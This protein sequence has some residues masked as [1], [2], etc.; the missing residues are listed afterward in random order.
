M[1][2]LQTVIGFGEAVPWPDAIT[3]AAISWL[4]TRT[5]QRLSKAKPD[6][7]RRFAASMAAYPI[8]LHSAAA[9]AQHYEIPQ[10]FF[11][12][13]LGPQRKYSC[14]LY[15][16]GTDTLAAA[17]ERALQVTAHHAGLADGQCIL[18][19]GCGWGSLSLWLAQ[20]YR[21]ARITAVSNSRSQRE[22]ILSVAKAQALA[23][24]EV[25][26]ADMNEF[27]PSGRFDRIVSVEMF[28][29]MANWRP[30]LQRMRDCVEA[31][32]RMFLHIFANSRAPYRFSIDERA[33][34][35]AQHY[36][37]GG[38]MPSH[39]L[40]RQFSDCFAVD[41]EWRWDG[42]HYARTARHW[43]QNFDSNSDAIS[44][45]LK[46]I[47]GADARLWRRRWR[48]FFLATAGLFAHAGGGEWG[49]S[50][51]LLAPNRSGR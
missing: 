12:L 33:D 6:S 35:I 26:T 3:Q 5:Q 32:G 8:A 27:R 4:V 37:T 15:E 38:I 25:I 43:L 18:D 50:H 11:A 40:I 47:Y 45:V 20:R 30:L 14:C 49:V 9:N 36:F 10:E 34:W 28:E 7:E 48:L 44:E 51:Y 23:N 29:H 42:R 39:N 2:A 17:E 22:F 46:R 31:D 21:A 16:G 13:I 1:T 24:L 19:L 41:R